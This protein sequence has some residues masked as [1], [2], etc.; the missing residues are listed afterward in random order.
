MRLI[1]GQWQIP[2]RSNCTRN[3]ASA[4]SR[5]CCGK[6][7]GGAAL[8]PVTC[9]DER[10]ACRSKHATTAS[11]ARRMNASPP[12]QADRDQ[13]C[14]FVQALFCN[15]DEG[16]FVSLRAFHDDE[17]RVFAIEGHALT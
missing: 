14:R 16:G 9:S 13:I 6:N 12:L 10:A 17:P 8:P 2:R 11:A 7:G 15:A 4:G 1:P 3:R 5:S